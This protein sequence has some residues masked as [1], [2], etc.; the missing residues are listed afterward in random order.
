M[1]RVF[2]LAAAHCAAVLS[3]T[4]VAFAGVVTVGSGS[5]VDFGSG[6]VDLG[7]AN[8][9]VEGTL[10]LGA[11]LTDNASYVTYKGYC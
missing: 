10:F 9:L 7:C 11:E 2:L 6:S 3:L 1:K 5:A 8:L 4:V